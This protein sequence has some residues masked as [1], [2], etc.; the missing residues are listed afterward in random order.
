[1]DRLPSALADGGNVLTPDNA[2][3]LAAGVDQAVPVEAVDSHAHVFVR[4]LPLAAERR[5]A[6]D[7]DA[8][9]DA[10]VSHLRANGLSHSVLVQ[11]S[12]LGTDNHYFLDVLKRYPQRFRG[13]AVIEPGTCHGEL[14]YMDK[15][16]VVGVR[17]NLIGRPLPDLR[18]GPWPDLLTRVNAMGWHVEIHRGAGDLAALMPALIE[19]QCTVVIDHFGRPDPELG[20]S[21]PGL[22]Y[23]CGTASTGRVWVK[24]SAAYRNVA[25]AS[26]TSLG[27]ALTHRLL[28]AF[29]PTRLV[30]G[31]DWPHTQHRDVI[32]YDAS[33][34]ALNQWIPDAFTRQIVLRDSPRMLFRLG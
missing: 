28:D 10:Y 13:V 19:Q 5:H 27:E 15:L 34:A 31:S 12:F 1:M 26:G 18:S 7:Y 23:L 9:L 32:D 29:G 11:P 30:W 20:A 8:T 25:D 6:P 3:W 24:L 17:L 4:G 22:D 2:R 16:G 33:R 21:D 14:A